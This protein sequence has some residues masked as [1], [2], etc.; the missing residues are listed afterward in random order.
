MLLRNVGFYLQVQMALL[1]PRRPKST[2]SPLLEH[3]VSKN[4]NYCSFTNRHIGQEKYFR[5]VRKICIYVG[6]HD[7]S[8][9]LE[10]MYLI[11]KI[12]R[13]KHLRTD[14]PLDGRRG[15]VL[16]WALFGITYEEIPYTFISLSLVN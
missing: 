2:S 15:I 5:L 3:Q 16:I 4:L 10:L 14:D 1:Q 9:L 7:C 6:S 13:R 8:I 12:N 11:T